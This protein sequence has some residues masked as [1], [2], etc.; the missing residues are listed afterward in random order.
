MKRAVKIFVFLIF[1]S[2]IFGI[3]LE[4]C[5]KLAIMNNTEIFLAGQDLEIAKSKLNQA[6]T[7]NFPKLQLG[8]YYNRYNLNYPA[9][10]S[11]A[12]GAFNLEEN[13][14][15]LYGTRIV[16]TQ[17]LYTGGKNK[18]L[19]KQAE[20]NLLSAKSVYLTM[21]NRLIYNVRK[22]YVD[23]IYLK[24]KHNILKNAISQIEKIKGKGK[25]GILYKNTKQLHEIE[26]KLTDA[27]FKLNSIVD[28]EFIDIEK[29]E[30]TLEVPEENFLE[31]DVQKYIVIALE[32]RP[33]FSGLRA[34][35][36]ID[37]LSVELGKNFRFPNIDLFSTYDYLKPS[38]GGWLSN[39][40]VGMSLSIPLFDGG[41]RWQQLK[42]KNALFK[43]TK[44]LV[45]SKEEEIKREVMEAL[46]KLKLSQKFYELAGK[47]KEEFSM[48]VKAIPEDIERWKEANFDILDAERKFI[49]AKFYL[50]YVTGE[51]IEKY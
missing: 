32:K 40:Q 28:T 1:C 7:V 36:F 25:E 51:D 3:C 18:T 26:I 11:S 24:K 12:I 37:S 48:P 20:Q 44:A 38:Q 5:I 8:A 34:R 45:G 35:E 39:F 17:P 29:I 33:E 14:Q 10:F 30:N 21:K 23:V 2:K 46:E 49:L 6:K 22:S 50:S 41:A 19:I 42:E 15:F 47:Q 13:S 4:E 9:I 43:K 31:E 16:L 27:I